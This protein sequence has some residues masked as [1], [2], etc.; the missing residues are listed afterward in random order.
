MSSN[1]GRSEIQY[2]RILISFLSTLSKGVGFKNVLFLMLRNDITH[3]SND[4]RSK[5]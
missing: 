3:N 1:T 5:N 4:N 2:K